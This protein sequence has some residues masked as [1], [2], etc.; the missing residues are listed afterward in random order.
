[1]AHRDLSRKAG[2]GPTQEEAPRLRELEDENPHYTSGEVALQSNPAADS[3]ALD[4]AWGEVSP[5]YSRGFCNNCY[6]YANNQLT[7]TFSQ[8]G[9]GGGKVFKGYSL[10]PALNS[11]KCSDISEAA[12]RDGL[13]MVPNCTDLLGAGAGWYVALLL[14]SVW[15]EADYHWLKQDQSGCWSYKLGGGVVWTT[16]TNGRKIRSPEHVALRWKWKSGEVMQYDK[17]CGYFRTNAGV[18]IKGFNSPSDCFD[19]GWC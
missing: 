12:V 7:D 11:Y 10:A 16:G 1:M 14:G 8:P 15:G 19:R 3:P 13:V 4:L 6:D 2:S 5:C 18:T 9:L 17:F